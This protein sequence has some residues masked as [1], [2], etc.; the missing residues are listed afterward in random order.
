M[1][2][3]NV[4]P[5]SSIIHTPVSPLLREA[6]SSPAATRSAWEKIQKTALAIF[7][8]IEEIFW[9]YVDDVNTFTQAVLTVVKEI[10]KELSDKLSSIISKLGILSIISCLFSLK[11]IP[12]SFQSLIDQIK[13][14]DVEGTFFS[15][16]DLAGAPL[17]ILDSIGAF[18]EA[19]TAF[20]AIPDIIFFS[21]IA[22][23]LAI[24]LTGISAFRG[25]YDLITCSINLTELPKSLSQDS[26]QDF[27][28]YLKSKIGVTVEEKRK[29]EERY[30][31]LKAQNKE[32]EYKSKIQHEVTI[33]K[34]QK[35]NALARRTDQKV[36]EIMQNLKKHLKK[37]QADLELA[38][39]GLADMRTL[40]GRKI[41]WISI[42]FAMDTACIT[43]LACSM[44]FPV[45]AYAA[46]AVSG[47]KAAIFLCRHHYMHT[48]LYKDLN[49]P[50]FSRISQIP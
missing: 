28:A 22:I 50:N 6:G 17:E 33:L 31:F 4:I 15:L 44:I 46:P 16:L 29:I 43:T 11:S 39:F 23:P 25:L 5:P 45:S 19:L 42:G 30:T 14:K 13:A 48:W 35:R 40:M 36:S 47:I 26:L 18:T 9:E 34:S 32:A 2:L 12:E 37:P 21:L 10:H 1:S 20:G 41:A 3:S 8:F 49:M 24:T 27:K 38:N 7:E